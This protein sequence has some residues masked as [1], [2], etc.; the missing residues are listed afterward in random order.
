M[1]Y[2][3]KSNSNQKKSPLLKR[4]QSEVPLS[5]NTIILKK[6]LDRVN[7]IKIIYICVC[8]YMLYAINI[9]IFPQTTC[10]GKNEFRMH[11]DVKK[12]VKMDIMIQKQKRIF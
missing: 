6:K 5:S 8:M 11:S 10:Q 7:K 9:Y 4:W 2:K 3:K 1:F 12:N